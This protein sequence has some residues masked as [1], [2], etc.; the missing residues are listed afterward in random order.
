MPSTSP[1][2]NSPRGPHARQVR[3]KPISFTITKADSALATKIVERADA[4]AVRM[5]R[6]PIPQLIMDIVACHA[7][8]TPLD[9]QRLLDAPEF[10]FVHD[11]WG[12]HKHIDRTTGEL[13]DC[14][15]PRTASPKG[16]AL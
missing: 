8:G 16:G 14:F 10:D 9:L 1:R 6:E 12:I 3:S 2:E 5:G 11:V 4:I 13:G 7:N 15:L